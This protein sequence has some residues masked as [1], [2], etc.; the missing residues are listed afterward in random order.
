MHE[1]IRKTNLISAVKYRTE[2][3]KYNAE[4]VPDYVY[5]IIICSKF[6]DNMFADTDA[7]L[8]KERFTNL[9]AFRINITITGFSV[10]AAFAFATIHVFAIT[11]SVHQNHTVG[12][13]AA[14]PFHTGRCDTGTAQIQMTQSRCALGQMMQCTVGNA[15][16]A[17][18]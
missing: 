2:D 3:R 10:V 14:K 7:F 6:V 18:Q 1:R 16:I 13:F 15:R 17:V 8:Q 4:N 9:C 5:Y 11:V 12:P